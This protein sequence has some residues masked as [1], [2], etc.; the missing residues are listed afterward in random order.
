[1]LPC[2]SQLYFPL[3]PP[4]LQ[5]TPLINFIVSAR[6]RFVDYANRSRLAR[7]RLGKW[8]DLHALWRTTSLP[9]LDIP[10]RIWVRLSP[11]QT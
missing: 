3:Q 5:Y 2:T 9:I 4:S 11:P 6:L 1:M 10:V 7:F 8:T